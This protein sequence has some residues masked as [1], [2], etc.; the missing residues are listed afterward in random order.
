MDVSAGEVV[1]N[2]GAV[3]FSTRYDPKKTAVRVEAEQA[4]ITFAEMV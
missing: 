1:V 4:E 3:V 2:G